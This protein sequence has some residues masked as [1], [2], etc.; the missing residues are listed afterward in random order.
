VSRSLSK[1]WFLTFLLV[2][3][4][5][6]LGIF[7]WSTYRGFRHRAAA[8]DSE[9]LIT[10]EEAG[11]I[12]VEVLNGSGKEGAGM[13]VAQVL[14][15]KGFDVVGIGNAEAQDFDKTIVVDRTDDQMSKARPV[16]R[17]LNVAPGETIPL[18]NSDLLLEVSVYVGKDYAQKIPKKGGSP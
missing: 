12:R 10:R 11:K 17:A 9:P 4:I 6:A 8:G 3:L 7:A 2:V 13:N 18:K 14:R 15:A 5:A 16:A 1:G